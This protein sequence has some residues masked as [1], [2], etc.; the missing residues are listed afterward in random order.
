M[1][2]SLL[3]LLS[4]VAPVAA[5]AAAG[6]TTCAAC[7]LIFT[8]LEQPAN[9]SA[10]TGPSP[11]ATCATL[12]VCEATCVLWAPGAWPSLAASPVTPTDGGAD[13]QRRRALR[14]GAG[15]GVSSWSPPSRMA[16]ADF[17]RALAA[18]EPAA[19]PS[20]LWLLVSRFMSGALDAAGVKARA[21]PEL[22]V[23]RPAM[24]R[25]APLAA[26]APPPPCDSILNV[27][28]DITRTFDDHLPLFD[29]DDDSFG[30]ASYGF[31]GASWRGKDCLDTDAGAYP[32][33]ADRGAHGVDVDV[34]CNGIAGGNATVPDFEAAFCSGADAP[35]GVVILGDSAAAHFHLPAQYVNA[36]CLAAGALSNLTQVLDLAANEA[37]WPECAWVT[38]FRGA[39]ACPTA[40]SLAA[41]F[42]S[43]YAASRA[44]NLCNHR[45]FIN[46]GVNGARV[47]SMAPPGG[48]IESFTPDPA[49]DAP[50]LV[51]FALIGNDVCNGH[52]GADSMTTVDDFQASVLASLDYLHSTLPRGSHVA[53]LGLVDGRVLWDTTHTNQ[54]PLGVGYPALYEYLACN[55]VTPCWGWLNSN[56]TWRDFTS[57]RAQNLTDVYDRII[58]T[59]SSRY[60]DVFDMYRLQVDWPALIQEYI[61]SGG[62][63]MDVV[64]SVDGF[65]PSQTGNQ[66][67]A[68][69]VWADL[70]ANRTS[71][72]PRENPHNADIISIFG[73][74]LN[75]Y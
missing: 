4:L 15:A 43:I 74:Q 52:P 41:N 42:T 27:S 45:N 40:T 62:D 59:N 29:A 33:R 64:E 66:L 16:A 44:Q 73:E 69:I 11:D 56:A 65:H 75:G 46:V 51:V 36:R 70:A 17:V 34:N 38:G 50:Y 24:A 72:L 68:R 57:A 7:G 48:I 47:G 55:G 6:G 37:D 39:G 67:L 8:L 30:E 71:W 21:V 60:Q 22:R 20:A 31:R 1:R 14:T 35:M 49:R 5:G 13:D 23:A 61:R 9:G 54:H 19:P 63:P 32:G 26:S 18:L 2:A 3:L 28:C 10:P 53:F 25:T 12:G 58:A